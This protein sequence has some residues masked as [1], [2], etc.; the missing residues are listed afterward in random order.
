VHIKS[1]EGQKVGIAKGV[2]RE[3]FRVGGPTE[4]ARPKYSTI[5][6]FSTLSV[7]YIKIRPPLPSCQRSWAVLIQMCPTL[8]LKLMLF[9]PELQYVNYSQPVLAI[10]VCS[11]LRVGYHN[12]DIQLRVRQSIYCIFFV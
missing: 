3:N 6:P 4:I 5:K 2:S 8:T 12:I 1:Q 7:T 11:R 10:T 9:P